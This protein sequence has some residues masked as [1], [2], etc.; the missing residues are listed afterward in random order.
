MSSLS[1]YDDEESRTASRSTVGCKKAS[2]WLVIDR[3]DK[4]KGVQLW[5]AAYFKSF[6]EALK[7]KIQAVEEYGTFFHLESEQVILYN[8]QVKDVPMGS[9]TFKGVTNIEML[10]R[11]DDYDED[12][13]DQV[14][15]L[16]DL[17]IGSSYKPNSAILEME[18]E[19][20]EIEKT[21][22]RRLKKASCLWCEEIHKRGPE[23]CRD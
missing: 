5:N 12:I 11:K 6:G 19:D 18:P 23:N 8:S 13:L 9:N 20:G 1:A 10:K 7:E 17:L 14:P 22:G 16:D 4:E 15:C 21:N 2:F 3:N